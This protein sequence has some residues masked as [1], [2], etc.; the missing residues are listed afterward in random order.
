MLFYFSQQSSIYYK[1]LDGTCY[2]DPGWFQ[3]HRYL[4]AS[5]LGTEI[6][7]PTKTFIIIKANLVKIS[8][9][10]AASQEVQVCT[11][12]TVPPG[13]RNTGSVTTL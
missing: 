5:V 7:R 9:P 4:P 3:T 13:V 12:L 11:P 1:V 2:A 8:C 10:Q 6:K